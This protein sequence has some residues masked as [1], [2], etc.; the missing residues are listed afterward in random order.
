MIIW[1]ARDELNTIKRQTDANRQTH[2][3]I[4]HPP[5]LVQG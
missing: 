5:F 3:L 1:L 4:Y 2:F